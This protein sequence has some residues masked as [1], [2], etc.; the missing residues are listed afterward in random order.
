MEDRP[1]YYIIDDTGIILS[2]TPG[3][4]ARAFVV[5]CSGGPVQPKEGE[6]EALPADWQGDL[7]L[8]KETSRSEREEF[9]WNRSGKKGRRRKKRPQA[10]KGKKK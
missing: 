3:K 10:G 5:M 8:A 7:I 2:G 4:M 6:R 9:D 1:T